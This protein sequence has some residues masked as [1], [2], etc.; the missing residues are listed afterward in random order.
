MAP[1]LQ[2]GGGGG[3]LRGVAQLGAGIAV[4]HVMAHALENI[5]FGG[6]HKPGEPA[7]T[8]EEI[9]ELE[10][11]VK[12]GPCAVQYRSFNTCL[13]HNEDDVSNCEWAFD[14]FKECQV[15]HKAEMNLDNNEF[16]EEKERSYI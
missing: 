4:G 8:E 16:N 3:F 7:P 12:K 15:M 10:Q 5:F 1:P 2:G 11:K 13:Q 9:Q 14:M 6:K